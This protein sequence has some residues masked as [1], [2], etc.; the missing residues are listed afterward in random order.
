M[1]FCPLMTGDEKI[2]DILA[3]LRFSL[4]QRGSCIKKD[5]KNL[6]RSNVWNIVHYAVNAGDHIEISS[7]WNDQ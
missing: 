1:R 7:F 6:G 5:I 3:I 4:V 2:T